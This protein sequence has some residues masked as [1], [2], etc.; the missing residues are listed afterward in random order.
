MR[1]TRVVRRS[2]GTTTCCHEL[3][4]FTHEGTEHC[5]GCLGEVQLAI[6]ER[7]EHS[8]KHLY[9]AFGELGLWVWRTGRIKQRRS[10]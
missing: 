1:V 5:R 4:T 8:I 9:L 2:D 6:V 7:E 10:V 3:T